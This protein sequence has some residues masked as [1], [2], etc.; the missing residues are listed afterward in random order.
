MAAV[1]QALVTLR[2]KLRF[3]IFV[4]LFRGHAG[5]CVGDTFPSHLYLEAGSKSR[6]SN[7][8]RTGIDICNGNGNGKGRRREDRR[9]IKEKRKSSTSL[10]AD[11]S[12]ATDVCLQRNTGAPGTARRHRP[13]DSGSNATP[14]RQNRLFCA[15][16]D[17]IFIRSLHFF[18]LPVL[19]ADWLPFPM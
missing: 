18:I 2:P 10:E 15:I 11:H 3:P 16:A 9:I 14:W 6:N 19:A 1:L 4:K 13:H 8:S 5:A 17:V 12:L 7:T